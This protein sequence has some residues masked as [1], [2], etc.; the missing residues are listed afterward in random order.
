MTQLV[1]VRHHPS[2]GKAILCLPNLQPVA[3]R[4]MIE[5]H[6][7]GSLEPLF[8]VLCSSCMQNVGY[9]IFP[10]NDRMECSTAAMDAGAGPTR[11]ADTAPS[12]PGTAS[13]QGLL[14]HV[15]QSRRSL[16]SAPRNDGAELTFVR[17]PLLLA[18]PTWYTLGN[19]QCLNCVWKQLCLAG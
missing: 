19:A 11:Q 9:T 8:N 6:T 10:H 17:R 18:L 13:P 2:A 5:W 16:R 12:A 4:A 7:T 3:H 14:P 15:A 1:T